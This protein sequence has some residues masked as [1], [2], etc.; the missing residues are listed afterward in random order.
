MHTIK[1]SNETVFLLIML[2]Q[3]LNLAV[4]IYSLASAEIF[5]FVIFCIVA[6]KYLF[7]Y[8]QKRKDYAKNTQ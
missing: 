6:P 1:H 8:S 5:N 3:Y 2:N 7:I 4:I